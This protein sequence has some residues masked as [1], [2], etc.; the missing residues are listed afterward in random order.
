MRCVTSEKEAANGYTNNPKG[1]FYKEDIFQLYFIP[2]S[3][4]I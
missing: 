1:Y 2:E 3:L 4:L